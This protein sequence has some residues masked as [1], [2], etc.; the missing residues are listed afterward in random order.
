MRLLSA[1]LHIIVRSGESVQE[2]P[3]RLD[4]S[5]GVNRWYCQSSATRV[6]AY[7][8]PISATRAT[9]ICTEPV[10]NQWCWYLQLRRV[11]GWNARLEQVHCRFRAGPQT[12]KCALVHS[13][14]FCREWVKQVGTAA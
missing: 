6:A 13:F 5:F 12:L 2:V 8:V 4:R 11:L 9:G 14:W 7:S 10:T 3:K 1:L